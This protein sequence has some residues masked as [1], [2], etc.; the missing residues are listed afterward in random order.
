V[1]TEKVAVKKFILIRV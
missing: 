1:S